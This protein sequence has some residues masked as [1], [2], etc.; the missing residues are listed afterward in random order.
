MA[1]PALH[2]LDVGD[3]YGG[4]SRGGDGGERRGDIRDAFVDEAVVVVTGWQALREAACWVGV[5]RVG[6]H[7]VICAC[8]DLEF[9][10]VGVGFVGRRVGNRIVVVGA[11][12]RRVAAAAACGA[13]VAAPV[14]VR[15]VDDRPRR[16]G[17][18]PGASVE[19][20]SRPVGVAVRHLDVV[21]G[22]SALRAVRTGA[23][24]HGVADQQEVTVDVLVVAGGLSG[25]E[26]RG[27]GF[28]ADRRHQREPTEADQGAPDDCQQAQGAVP[29]PV[30]HAAL[31]PRVP[32][33][34]RIRHPLHHARHFER[35]PAVSC[36]FNSCQR[37]RRRRLK[38]THA[39]GWA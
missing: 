26:G 33:M 34:P 18:R 11:V 27:R 7:L 32:P 4:R 10:L 1:V 38:P 2:G 24:E 3:R 19:Q 6:G 36:R 31:P 39:Y 20:R 29:E 15:R 23:F 25:P 30:L 35:C 12:V 22:P 13:E 14:Q 17:E 8:P 5:D 9:H 28:V 21:V 37:F 16:D